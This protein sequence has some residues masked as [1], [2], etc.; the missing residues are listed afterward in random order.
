M[1]QQWNN[2]DKS[3]FSASIAIVKQN[4]KQNSDIIDDKSC[5]ENSVNELTPV[6][7]NNVTNQLS[8][9]QSLRR[10]FESSIPIP[11]GASI[12]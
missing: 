2:R 9:H 12:L 10:Y 8:S 3:I 11:C 1:K 7:M 4:S 5:I 6:S